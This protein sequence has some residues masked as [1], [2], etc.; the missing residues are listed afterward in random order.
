ML[1]LMSDIGHFLYGEGLCDLWCVG[2]A[3]V[4]DSFRVG[5]IMVLNKLEFEKGVKMKCVWNV[6][7]MKTEKHHC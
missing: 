5:G 3:G 1:A 2:Y 4:Y 7:L 6:M